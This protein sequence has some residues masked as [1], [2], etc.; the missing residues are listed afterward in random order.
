MKQLLDTILSELHRTTKRPFLIAVDGM[1]G[2]GKTTLGNYLAK[3]LNASLFHMD[4]FFLQPHQ[5]IEA[6]LSEPGG[7]VDYERFKAEV[8][9]H[10]TDTAGVT[11]RPFSCH[12][13]KLADKPITVPYNNIVIVEG[14]YSH[15]PYFEDIYNIK[16]FLEISPEEQKKRI[17]A[18]DGEAIWPMFE[19]KWIP[20]ENRY[21]EEFGIKTK[22]DYIIRISQ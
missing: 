5:R 16:I 6:R 9:D 8:L 11:Y 20:M 13:W 12:E 14:S 17:I 10:V 19:Q 1:C 22:S 2:S 15:H 21:F 7:N 4:D 18:R 3:E